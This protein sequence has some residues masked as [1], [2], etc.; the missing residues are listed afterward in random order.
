MSGGD[1][2]EVFR[3]KDAVHAQIVKA[4]LENEGIAAHVVGEELQNAL[5]ELPLGWSSGPSI[6]VDG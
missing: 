1:P 3:A 6:L 2:G 5:G 4:A